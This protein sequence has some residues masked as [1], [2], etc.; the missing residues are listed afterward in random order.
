MDTHHHACNAP[1]AEGHPQFEEP[2]TECSTKWHPDRPPKLEI[3]EASP[4]D[5]P[6]HLGQ[7]AEPIQD[8]FRSGLRAEEDEGNPFFGIRHGA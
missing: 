4:D 8:G 2:L 7:L 6:V 3:L 1:T 5:P